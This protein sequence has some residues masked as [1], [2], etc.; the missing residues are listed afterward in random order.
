MGE[1][2]QQR[3]DPETL[4]LVRRQSEYWLSGRVRLT[5]FGLA[6]DQSQAEKCSLAYLLAD[7]NVPI[8][9]TE[10]LQASEDQTP[11]QPTIH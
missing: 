11:P 2:Q 6:A 3:Q 8:C 4:Q 9:S 1:V 5:G 7:L 10:P